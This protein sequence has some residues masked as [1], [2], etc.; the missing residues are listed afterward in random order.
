MHFDVFRRNLTLI[1]LIIAEM[2]LC[3]RLHLLNTFCLSASP[4][5]HSHSLLVLSVFPDGAL[6]V[7]LC[8]ICLIL[9]LA[10]LFAFGLIFGPAYDS[11]NDCFTSKC[12]KCL[13]EILKQS[14]KTSEHQGQLGCSETK[15]VAHV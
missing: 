14:V 8:H 13:D 11:P 4:D 6:A 12:L 9:V 10:G 5:T 2:N 15:T 1:S 3:R 7:D